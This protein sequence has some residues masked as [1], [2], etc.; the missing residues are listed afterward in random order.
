MKLEVKNLVKNFGPQ[1]GLSIDHLLVENCQTLVLIGPSG[2]GK[3]TFLKLIEGLQYPDSGSIFLNDKEII[4]SEDALREHRRMIGMVFQSWNL[5]PHLTALENIILPLHYV[6]QVNKKE[7]RQRSLD[8]LKRFSLDKHANKKPHELSGGQ[9]QRVA[10]IRAIAIHPQV[11]ILDE[12][13][14]ALDPSM[15]YEV[16][17]LI[18]EIKQE[19][20][21]IIMATHHL[22][23][24]KK[25]ADRILFLC[26]GKILENGTP[27]EVYENPN[28]VAAKDYMSKVLNN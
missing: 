14:S 16:L 12:P 17:D 4:Y 2:S 26:E 6:H 5:F 11:L 13:T 9:L 22:H 1:Q 20:K 23:F 28:S 27:E 15:T 7:A 25:T 18:R 19:K 3:S 8:L 24:A 21:D 10:L